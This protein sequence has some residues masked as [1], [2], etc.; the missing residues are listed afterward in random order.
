MPISYPVC[1]VGNLLGS[2]QPYVARLSAWLCVAVGGLFMAVFACIIMLT[3]NHL[4][5]AFTP[6][7]PA[8]I[9]IMASIAPLA[10]LFQVTPDN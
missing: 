2:G 5:K 10:A 9:S 4:G 7:D 6:D 8:V 1:R 3:R